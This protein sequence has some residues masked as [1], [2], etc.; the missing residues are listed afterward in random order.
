MLL[1]SDQRDSDRGLM[2]KLTLL[3]L[4]YLGI[5]SVYILRF[6]LVMDE[7][8]TAACVYRTIDQLVPYRDY[9]PYKTVLGYYLQLPIFLLPFRTWTELLL[10]KFEMAFVTAAA[11]L[12]AAWL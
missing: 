10:A 7:F 11:L 9:V 1:T 8:A 5:E 2:M 6:P 3:L 4:S 12:W